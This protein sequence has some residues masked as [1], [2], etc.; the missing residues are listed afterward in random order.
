MIRRWNLD[1]RKP[2]EMFVGHTATVSSLAFSPDAK[3][4]SPAVGTAPSS[5]GISGYRAKWLCCGRTRD[6]SRSGVLARGD[7]LATSSGDGTVR[8]RRAT[9]TVDATPEA[10]PAWRAAHPVGGGPFIDS[11]GA[12]LFLKELP[13]GPLQGRLRKAATVGTEPGIAH[14]ES[15]FTSRIDRNG[16]HIHTG[17][18]PHAGR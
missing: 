3:R 7:V 15:P 12:E 10:C 8:L 2:G 1:Q 11:R 16:G 17:E 4:S 13:G 18:R 6:R 5:S 14:Y 9:L